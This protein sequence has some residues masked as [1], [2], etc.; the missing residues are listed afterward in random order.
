MEEALAQKLSEWQPE[1]VELVSSVTSIG[2]RATAELIVFTKGFEN[3]ENYRQLI[4]YCG[5]SPMEN[6]SGTSLKGRAKIC[7]NGGG[8]I[9]HI[10]YMCAMNRAANRAIK[11]NPACKAVYDRL[12]DNGKNK[13]VALIAVCT[14]LLKQVF[15]VVN[16]KTLFDKNYE[17]IA[18]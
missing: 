11:N 13:R 9:R 8:R 15:G 12:V 10:L 2:K 14:K 17:K 18:A 7:K 6:T 4:S 5:L 1:L 3:M 16:S